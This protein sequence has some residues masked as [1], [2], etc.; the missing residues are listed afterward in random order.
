[1]VVMGVL[2]D[3]VRAEETIRA[4]EVWRRANR[5]IGIGPIGVMVRSVSGAVGSRPYGV[6]KVEQGAVRGLVV[7]FF[8]FAL[9]AAG[10]AAI[11]G[12]VLGSIVFGLAGLV[13]IVPSGQTAIMTLGL[14]GI[15]ALLAALLVGLLGLLVGL[16]VGALVGFIDGTAR[17]FTRSEVSRSLERLDPGRWG[18][19]VRAPVSAE[20]LVR[21]ELA[22]LGSEPVIGIARPAPAGPVAP[23]E[24]SAPDTPAETP[25]EPAAPPSAVEKV[26]A[27]R[28]RGGGG[29]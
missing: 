3:G 9:P 10:A 16:A 20:P 7:G 24:T 29:R 13:G 11:A 15:A 28:T 18:V 23:P 14:T 21:E 26:P 6:I 2:D 12:Y 27:G 5:R 8:V 4:I 25:V 1:M 19:A 17:G 22:R